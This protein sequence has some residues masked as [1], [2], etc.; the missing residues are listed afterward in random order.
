MVVLACFAALVGIAACGSSS[1]KLTSASGRTVTIG[2]LIDYTGAAASSEK[3]S[4]M[5][6]QAGR[7]LAARQ[8]INLKY[9]LGD[10]ATTPAGALAAAQKFVDKDHVVA[11]I[12][13]SAVAFSA[14]PFTISPSS[15]PTLM[16]TSG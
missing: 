5:G 13:N 8:G 2:V 9:V 16:P 3:S 11:V 12:V 4:V 14:A 10:T 15:V 1:S 7:V 6:V